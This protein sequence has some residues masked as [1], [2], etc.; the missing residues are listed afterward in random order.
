MTQESKKKTSFIIYES[1]YE[2]IKSLS[3]E[4]MGKL[5][6]AIF[7]YRINGT[8]EVPED[9]TIAFSF[10]K[11][12]LDIDTQKYEEVCKKRAISGSTG[13]KQKVANASKCYQMQANATKC[14]Q[15]VANAS[16]R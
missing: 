8:T 11:N 9:I 5:F 16:K 13:G 10:F 4:K 6:R 15:K 2:P 1:F 14:K 3:D 12:Q 7:E